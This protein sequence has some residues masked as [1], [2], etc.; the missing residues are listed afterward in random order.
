L[1]QTDNTLQP[2]LFAFSIRDL[3]PADSD[4]WLYIDLFD[5]LDL[6]EFDWDYSSQGQHA[7]DPKLML[8]TIFY[9][10]THRVSS[11]RRLAV[12]CAHDVRFLVLS[13]EQY[14]DA[15]TFH[16]FIRRHE[17]RMP[18]LFAQVVRLAMKMG[19]ANLGRIA[20]E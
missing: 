15:R 5:E 19:L 20:I 18:E 2:Q 17:E 4:I 11:G 8:R 13:G 3:V 1:F 7:K 10:L 9:G 16:R 6:E 12:A 14:P